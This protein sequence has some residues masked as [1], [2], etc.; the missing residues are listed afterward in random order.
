MQLAYYKL[1]FIITIL[2]GL[3]PWVTSFP[4][5]GIATWLP[6]TI[7]IGIFIKIALS[8]RRNASINVFYICIFSV[9]VIQMLAQIVRG[10]GAGNSAVLSAIIISAFF[11]SLFKTASINNL[12][13]ILISQITIIYVVHICF[14]LLESVLISSNNTGILIVLSNGTHKAS[15]IEL[16]GSAPQSLFKQSQASSQLCVFAATWFLAMYMARFRLAI[17]LNGG[18]GIVLCTAIIL[19]VIYPTT[20][21][22]F[23]G[24]IMLVALIY[25]RPF[26]GTRNVR[27]MLSVVMISFMPSIYEWL[28]HKVD[29]DLNYQVAE[30]YWTE[31]IKPWNEFL[32]LPLSDQLFGLGSM[33]EVTK[34]GVWADFGASIILLQ[35]GLVTPL[36]VLALLLHSFG[37]I[38]RYAY[39]QY[40]NNVDI[41]PWLWLGAVN[42]LLAAG[43]LLSLVHYTVSLQVGGRTLFSLHIAVMLFSLW[44]MTHFSRTFYVGE[45][46]GS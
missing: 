22:G 39:S 43:N 3:L 41:Y 5:L 45:I 27:F 12:D 40:L 38:F 24:L 8:N 14:I 30:I 7:A 9:F 1:P 26:S 29:Y 46:H 6:E 31:V 32:R 16:N 33:E 13:R 21:I 44:K 20:T 18:Y 11:F 10:Q 19:L 15:T 4:I 35:M 25:M 34:L 23:V 37:K 28:F 17:K 2:A 42:A 36:I